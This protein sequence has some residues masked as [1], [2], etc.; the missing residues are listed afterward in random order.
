MLDLIHIYNCNELKSAVAINDKYACYRVITVRWIYF[1]YTNKWLISPVWANFFYQSY[2][3]NVLV[4]LLK[5]F[6]QNT[7]EC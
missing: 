3:K 7:D 1:C 6:P 2:M 5:S 4:D